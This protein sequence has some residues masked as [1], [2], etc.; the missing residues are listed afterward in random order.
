MGILG[1]WADYLAD[2]H[3]VSGERLTYVD[4]LL[5]EALDWHRRFVPD[6]FEALP[7]LQQYLDRFEKLPNLE[8]YFA[9]DEYTRLPLFGPRAQWGNTC[10]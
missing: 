3:W 10:E 7:A 1:L 8:G 5:H 2:S 6:T 9:S 4:F